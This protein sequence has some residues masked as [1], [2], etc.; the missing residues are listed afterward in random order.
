MEGTLGAVYYTSPQSF[1]LTLNSRAPSR[2]FIAPSPPIISAPI[3]A[4]GQIFFVHFPCLIM[5][6]Q[7]GQSQFS[8]HP[9]V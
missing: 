2:T 5:N 8:L 4:R 9:F 3:R 7:V 6:F 1:M